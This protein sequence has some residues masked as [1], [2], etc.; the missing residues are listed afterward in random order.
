MGLPSTSLEGIYRNNMEDVKRFFNTRHTN[1]YKVY[2]LCE[3]KT[4]PKD[5]FFNKKI[6]IFCTANKISE[7]SM[8]SNDTDILLNWNLEKNR[9]HQDLIIKWPEENKK[10]KHMYSYTINGFSLVNQNYGC[11]EN[12]FYFYHIDN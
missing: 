8:V 2:N 10:I 4:Y 11:Y 9:I 3:E 12:N 6:K 5:S 7:E 1:H